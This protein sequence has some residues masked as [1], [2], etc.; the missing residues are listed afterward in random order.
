M[1]DRMVISNTSPLVYLHQVDRIGTLGVLV[2]SKKEGL[3]SKITPVIEILRRTTM[4]LSP[5]LISAVLQEA[6]EL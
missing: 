5:E 6:G 2:K 1:L 3:L 4:Y